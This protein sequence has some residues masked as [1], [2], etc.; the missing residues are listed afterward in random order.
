MKQ[1]EKEHL[2]SRN[3]SYVNLKKTK[4]EQGVTLM[5]LVIT[6]IVLLILAGITI[7]MAL[8]DN[9]II[10]QA[11]N[12]KNKY[13]SSREAEQIALGQASNSI[14]DA[15]NST[16]ETGGSG[17]T[18][19]SSS[20][21]GGTSGNP[22]NLQEQIDK[23]RQ[24][25]EELKRENEELKSQQATGNATP[26]QVLAG[27]TFST[28]AKI[29]QTGTM[30]NR[31]GT[32]TSWSGYETISVEPHP[33]DNEQALV[34]IPNQYGNIGFFGKNSKITGNIANLSAGNIKAGVNVGRSDGKSGIVGTFTSDG[35]A[36]ADNI[37]KGK[38]AY[39]NGQKIEGNGANDSN[40][41]NSG[42]VSGM[43]AWIGGSTKSTTVCSNVGG[44]IAGNNRWTDNWS[45]SF[46]FNKDYNV[47]TKANGGVL[48]AL[49]IVNRQQGGQAYGQSYSGSGSFS[50][51]DAD[52]TV[53]SSRSYSAN[54]QNTSTDKN[55]I[56]FLE[57]PYTASADNIVVSIV[58]NGQI[59][60]QNTAA[61]GQASVTMQFDVVAKYKIPAK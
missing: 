49:A 47:P 14:Q 23:L 58:A 42:F 57:K 6:I 50:V 11:K 24:E 18:G 61:D 59:G 53:I 52:G 30:K 13:E 45:Q 4:S 1:K 12:A 9:G 48:Y 36:T 38:I 21:G 19:G 5:A 25:N 32:T 60:R 35:T 39:V 40:N 16:G 51:K 43:S 34:T 10:K 20:S 56:D 3:V 27:A 33:Q 7:Q 55:T 41:Y 44:S 54:A 22:D 28:A 17:G 46:N 31:D 2:E 37:S 29:G 8:D 26:E 15:M